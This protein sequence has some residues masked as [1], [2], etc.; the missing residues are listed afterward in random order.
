MYTL[1]SEIS[2]HDK[3]CTSSLVRMFV[4]CKMCL[5][6]TSVKISKNICDCTNWIS[7]VYIGVYMQWT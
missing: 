4:E 1:T 2:I 3:A 7:Y 5:H 6:I